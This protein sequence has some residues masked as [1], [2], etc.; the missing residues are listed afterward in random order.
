MN[1]F[2]NTMSFDKFSKE[3][4]NSFQRW[5][6]KIPLFSN[7]QETISCK[8][9]KKLGKK[10]P[11][12]DQYIPFHAKLYSNQYFIFIKDKYPK[13]TLNKIDF[14]KFDISFQQINLPI[15]LF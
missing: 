7:K 11:F 5:Y 3:M 9:N 4:D 10:T 1:K 13:K 2:I 6:F 12:I 8:L 14:L 15:E